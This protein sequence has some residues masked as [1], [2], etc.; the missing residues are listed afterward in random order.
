MRRLCVGLAA[1]VASSAVGMMP[2][3]AA[4]IAHRAYD[5]S[6]LAV[7]L[8][9]E[10]GSHGSPIPARLFTTRADVSNPPRAASARASRTDLGLLEQFV[11]EQALGPAADAST[12]DR[13]NGR[14]ART[15]D[16][17]AVYT[18][19]VDRSPFATSTATATEAG[20]GGV[21]MG[22]M[23]STSTA[24][25][26]GTRLVARA[27]TEMSSLVLGPLTAGSASYHAVATTSG[28]NGGAHATGVVAVSDATVAGIPVVV[29]QDGVRVDSTK[30]PVSGLDQAAAAVASAF[31]R[32]G[33][34][35]VRAVQP[36]AR[37][38]KNGSAAEV[39]GGGLQLIGRSDPSQSY[40]VAATLLSGDVSVGAGDSL[41]S[42]GGVTSSGPSFGTPPPGSTTPGS[43][44]TVGS[45]LP[46][47]TVATATGQPPQ[48]SPLYTRSASD[49]DLAH[50]WSGWPVLL[51]V[52]LGVLAV[53]TVWRRRLGQ[54]ANV[55][56]DRYVRG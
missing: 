26:A 29:T 43:S 42:L 23:K 6:A 55:L 36:T 51:F 25:L 49:A 45:A 28:T 10:A 12:R 27:D 13:N 35:D 46:G 47:G 16:G 2:A 41:A 39:S 40:F 32:S 3:S 7:P 37:T 34:F 33:Y 22:N 44:D 21:S 48:V 14:N 30:V 11:P 8:D 53:C 9:P 15:T 20:A 17:S 56:A 54:W 38:A 24:R 4:P 52:L 50:V 18:A 5:A 31:A 19:H 1:L